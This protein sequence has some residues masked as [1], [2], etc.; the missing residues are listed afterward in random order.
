MVVISPC[1]LV[2][3]ML[4][5]RLVS[6]VRPDLQGKGA[7]PRE[8]HHRLCIYGAGDGTRTRDS[9]PGRKRVRN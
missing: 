4:N 3:E 6:I 5:K 7:L 8:R 9:L 2:G 1:T